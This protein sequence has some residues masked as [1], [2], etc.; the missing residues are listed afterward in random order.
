MGVGASLNAVISAMNTSNTAFLTNSSAFVSAPTGASPDASTGGVWAR[1]VA[2]YVDNTA[3]TEGT[4]DRSKSKAGRID[5]PPFTPD[6]VTGVGTCTGPLH[7]EY[8]GYQFGFDLGK[9]NIGG[10]GGNLHF[11]ITLGYLRE[12]S[13]D[14]TKALTYQREVLFPFP[15]TIDVPSPPGTLQ[16]DMHVPSV[17]LYGVYT[18]GNFFADALVRGDYYAMRFSDKLNGLDNQFQSAHGISVGANA[19]YRV[20]L[21]SNWF[22]EPSAGL[23]WSQVRV[24]PISTPG[25]EADEFLI[26]DS[27]FPGNAGVVKFDDVESIL[28]RASLRVGMTATSGQ[29]TWQPFLTG[30]VFREFA[31]KAKAASTLGGPDTVTCPKPACDPSNDV[32]LRNGFKDTVLNTETSRIGTYYQAGLGFSVSM[33][34]TGWLGYARADYKTGENVDALGVNAGIRYQW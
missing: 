29:T 19:G 13:R 34:D 21:P 2:G 27:L 12:Y 26:N 28:G 9:L 3:T 33:G 6:P 22:I 32:I 1:T 16:A 4:V 5:Q 31:G 20:S 7:E 8:A 25:A 30:S 17:G 23:I 24:K 15:H 10:N 11:G 14:E 18:Q